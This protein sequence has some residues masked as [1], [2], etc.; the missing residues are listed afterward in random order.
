[1]KDLTRS[2]MFG[3]VAVVAAAFAVAL[4]LGAVFGTLTSWDVIYGTGGAIAGATVILL[5]IKAVRS[6]GSGRS[7]AS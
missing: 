7:S 5:V 4:L 6:A 3:I 2:R 1:M